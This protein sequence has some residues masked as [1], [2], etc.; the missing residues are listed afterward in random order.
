MTVA[1]LPFDVQ[2]YTPVTRKDIS[3]RARVVVDV[4]A[5]ICS[6]VVSIVEEGRETATFGEKMVRAA[7]IFGDCRILIDNKGVADYNKKSVQL[8]L[9]RLRKV[10]DPLLQVGKKTNKKRKPI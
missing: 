3:S 4:S 1:Y 9:E 5:D 10:L 2:T 7:L 8:N 6:Q